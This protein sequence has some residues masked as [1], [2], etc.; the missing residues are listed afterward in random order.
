LT[1]DI[2]AG[3][4]QASSQTVTGQTTF[5]GYVKKTGEGTWIMD[6]DMLAGASSVRRLAG[7]I[8]VTDPDAVADVRLIPG[9]DRFIFDL[10][11]DATPESVFPGG[12]DPTAGQ[13]VKLGAEELVVFQGNLASQPSFVVEEGTLRIVGNGSPQSAFVENNG[14][15]ILDGNMMTYIG[16]FFSVSGTGSLLRTGGGNVMLGSSTYTGG[17]T[18]EN[19]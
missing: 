18:I 16:E 8:I 5:S 4:T 15:L 10:G 19:G 11:E 3:M 2:G 1:L 9:D 14:A 7:S 17:T 13:F 12:S 6:S